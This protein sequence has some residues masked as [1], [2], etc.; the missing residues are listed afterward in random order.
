MNGP[1]D[2]TVDGI[3]WP[4]EDA[5]VT[6]ASAGLFEPP[7]SPLVELV[8][9]WRCGKL[10]DPDAACPKCGAASPTRSSGGL[11][12]GR[13]PIPADDPSIVAPRLL[14]IFAGLLATSVVYGWFVDFGLSEEVVDN[15]ESANRQVRQMIGLEGVDVL[16]ILVGLYWI[17]RPGRSA[18]VSTLR[19]V[20][21]WAVSPLALGLALA[22][23][24]GYHR[25]IMD[26]LGLPILEDAIVAQ[27]GLSLPL[28]LA[29]CVQPAIFEELF[30]RH[31]TLGSL[32][33]V[34]GVHGAVLA[35]SVMFGV[36]HVGVPLSIP[37]LTL[38]GVL[39]GYARVFSGGL[40]LPVVLHF[41]H[42]LAVVL[43]STH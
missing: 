28:I 10:V 7:P 31:L 2:P 36:G 21:A 12:A 33:G 13:R 24:F 4:P 32:R 43:S 17:P 25:V 41:A 22:A 5:D 3:D 14:L 6:P 1:S 42:N 40:A 11:G 30:F 34:T 39:F 9:C 29:Y 18:S 38:L 26:L 19:R 27:C 20:G 23:N 15:P 16:L 35:S 8:S 37:M